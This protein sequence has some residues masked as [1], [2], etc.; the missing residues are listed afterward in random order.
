ME[1]YNRK[2]RWT[3][4]QVKFLKENFHNMKDEI[5]AEVLGRTVK[6]VRHKRQR[7]DLDKASAGTGVVISKKE[8]DRQINNR[9]AA[10]R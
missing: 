9:D 3:A 6:S 8:Y 2:E 5:I 10:N 1:N 7:L 4:N